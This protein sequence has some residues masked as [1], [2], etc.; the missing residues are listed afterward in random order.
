MIINTT[1]GTPGRFGNHF[2]R[3]LLC[4]FLAIKNNIK[5]TYSY[6]NEFSELGIDLYKDGINNYSESIDINEDNF[7]YFIEKAEPFYKNIRFDDLIYIYAQTKEFSLY[8]KKFIYTNEQK[9]KIINKN[10][11]KER[12]NNNNDVFLHIRMGDVVH[13][14]PGFN[15]YDSVLSKLTFETGYISSD[16]LEHPMC[17]FLIN[18]YKLKSVSEN[19][20]NTIMYAST[21]KHIILSNGTFSWL[22]GIFGFYSDVYYPKMKTC[23][24]GDIFV[25]SDW[26]EIDTAN[27][28]PP[29]P[30]NEAINLMKYRNNNFTRNKL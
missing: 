20:V 5:F 26:N 21:C 30:Y 28:N 17:I 14:N 11:F 25:F 6:L 3:N 23:W 19:E 24:H 2:F 13:H 16:L 8:I 9:Q 1:V 10:L 4:H 18:K 12:Y 29:L 15:Y 7:F 22:I 27:S